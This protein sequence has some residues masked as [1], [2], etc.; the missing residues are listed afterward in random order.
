MHP[1]RGF[2]A[3]SSRCKVLGFLFRVFDLGFLRSV[4]KCQDPT[5]AVEELNDGFAYEVDIRARNS[6]GWVHLIG[7]NHPKPS[8]SW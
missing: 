1:T 6:A 3:A 7:E 8:D 4:L 2:S 5:I